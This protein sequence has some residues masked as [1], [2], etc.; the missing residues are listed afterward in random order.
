M[1][2]YACS[3]S[4]IVGEE[5]KNGSCSHRPGLAAG[6]SRLGKDSYAALQP[7]QIPEI[8]TFCL[9]PSLKSDDQEAGWSNL[10]NL[11]D[12]Q[13]STAP[14]ELLHVLFPCHFFARPLDHRNPVI[15]SPRSE[16]SQSLQ[17]RA[18]EDPQKPD[19]KSFLQFIPSHPIT[20]HFKV[21]VRQPPAQPR[22]LLRQS[23]W[24]YH[25]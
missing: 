12:L 20:S 21:L 23:T 5:R 14:G 22:C 19:P 13:I 1:S 9:F 8:Q 7:H 16:N 3:P 10:E 11:L 2:F 25:C 4:F 18:N 24:H 15:P 6:Q 17:S